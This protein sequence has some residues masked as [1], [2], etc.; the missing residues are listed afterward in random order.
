MKRVFFFLLFLSVFSCK[1]STP[2]PSMESI[3]WIE[4]QWEEALHAA[5]TEK[6]LLLIEF[7]APWCI[8]CNITEATVLHHPELV[9]LS[10]QFVAVRLDVDKGVNRPAVQRYKET[11]IPLFIVA[12]SNGA[13]FSRLSDPSVESL[14][15]L[16]LS[17]LSSGKL[18]SPILA[19]YHGL[20]AE[21]DGKTEEAG[22][23]YKQAKP[24]YQRQA[25]SWELASILRFQL[26]QEENIG[27]GKEFLKLFPVERG[28]PY[29]L[30]QMAKIQETDFAKNYYR[31]QA[32]NT[33]ESYL[34]EKRFPSDELVYL[35]LKPN[36]SE[37]LGGK[38]EREVYQEIARVAEKNP[39]K[40]HRMRAVSWNI[41]GKD[42]TRAIRL[43]QNGI[44]D[45]PEEYTF[46]ELLAWAYAE[47][48]DFQQAVEMQKQVIVLAGET[49]KP[50]MTVGLAEYMAQGGHLP[51]AIA[52][53]E[54]FVATLK[55]N[56][57][58]SIRRESNA[59]KNAEKILKEWREI[60]L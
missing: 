38:T 55:G 43:A 17:S 22:K 54:N 14:K 16:M 10:K 46:H 58:K 3:A 60:F 28:R 2:S 48:G 30:M 5:K 31:Q 21:M 51:E 6:K 44:R 42:F 33:I 32:W 19:F 27:A 59:F 49:A 34:K 15:N 41:R 26:E 52:L 18:S 53:L 56:D 39:E 25:F 8:Y 50:K 13:E 1:I 9:E 29:V 47:Q 4:D 20:K 45:Y 37:N 7:S 40:P 12:D 24:H 57:S 36:L 11:G 23:Q 35:S